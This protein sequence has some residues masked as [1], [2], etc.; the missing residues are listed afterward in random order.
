ME[1]YIVLTHGSKPVYVNVNDIL[2]LESDGNYTHLQTGE[3]RFTLLIALK[4]LL[5]KWRF[6]PFTRVHRSYAINR[7]KVHDFTLEYIMVGDHRVPVG[8]SFSKELKQ[9]FYSVE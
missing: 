3:K 7:N 8:K 1:Q 5:D 6:F 2:F 4:R 9:L